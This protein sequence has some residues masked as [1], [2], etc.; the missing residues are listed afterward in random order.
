MKRRASFVLAVLAIAAPLAACLLDLPSPTVNDLIGFDG[1]NP[2]GSL[3]D[4]FSPPDGAMDGGADVQV[5]FDAGPCDATACKFFTQMGLDP[6]FI[7]NDGTNLYFASGSND[8][9][10]V[11]ITTKAFTPLSSNVN[12]IIVD[13]KVTGGYFYFV[14]LPGSKNNVSRCPTNQAC[15]NMRIDYVPDGGTALQTTGVAS[16]GTSVF[17]TL[18]ELAG[19]IVKCGAG[20]PCGGLGTFKADVRP[21]GILF[22]TSSLYWF[23][24][25]GAGVFSCTLPSCAT[26]VSTGGGS[27]KDITVYSATTYWLESGGAV[28]RKTGNTTA[29]MVPN[30]GSNKGRAIRA[31][32]MHVYYLLDDALYRCGAAADCMSNNAELLA[33]GL[34]SAFGLTLTS[35][36]A[37]FTTRAPDRTIYR[38]AK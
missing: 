13:L 11:N 20:A 26:V 12:D 38:V 21:T 16:D 23:N 2:D 18:N 35:N 9:D 8:I 32:A 36:A 34:P 5:G 1:S 6:R 30:A 29:Q 25:N 17:F 19:G 33:G 28:W 37:F 7:E 10:S 27:I 15:S 3:P 4:G 14:S 22:D 31:D 24:Q